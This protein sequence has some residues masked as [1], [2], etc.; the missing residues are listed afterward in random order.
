MTHDRANPSG[1]I[2]LLTILSSVTGGTVDGGE[3]RRSS[4]SDLEVRDAAWDKA[5]SGEASRA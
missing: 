1:A 3:R 5:R 4:R 2:T